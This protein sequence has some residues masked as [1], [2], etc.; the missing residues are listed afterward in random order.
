M[1]TSADCLTTKIELA[2]IYNVEARPPVRTWCGVF[3]VHCR[4]ILQLESAPEAAAAP[5]E[6]RM[7]DHL[8]DWLVSRFGDTIRFWAWRGRLQLS[9]Q[10]RCQLATPLVQ[11]I[12]AKE[13]PGHACE[14][15]CVDAKS[16]SIP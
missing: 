3:T 8:Y 15:E 10:S 4:E 16:W 13:V 7:R 9:Y 1:L 12:A 14:S 11:H 5:V 6:S 2:G